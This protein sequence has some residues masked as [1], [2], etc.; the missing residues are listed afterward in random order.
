MNFTSILIYGI[1]QCKWDQFASMHGK[2]PD[3]YSL[4][5]ILMVW[6]YSQ[7]FY[8][9]QIFLYI[10]KFVQEQLSVDAF[11]WMGCHCILVKQLGTL[12]FLFKNHQ[13][14]VPHYPHWSHQCLVTAPKWSNIGLSD[15]Q[16]LLWPSLFGVF[17]C[18]SGHC[19][20]SIKYW[21]IF[22]NCYI[23]WHQIAGTANQVTKVT[24]S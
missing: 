7:I 1:Y 15:H 13:T 23:I 2:T 3:S 21:T 24:G 19:I 18:V 22:I 11:K 17:T 9:E 6:R 4:R 20:W 10:H 8:P 16:T 12:A 14:L 5:K